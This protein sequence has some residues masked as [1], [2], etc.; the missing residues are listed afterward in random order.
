MAVSPPEGLEQLAN[1]VDD[2][3]SD[4]TDAWAHHRYVSGRAHFAA[5]MGNAESTMFPPGYMW[6]D[7]AAINADIVRCVKSNQMLNAAL[8]ALRDGSSVSFEDA[9]IAVLHVA[10]KMSNMAVDTFMGTCMQLV[11]EKSVEQL[12]SELFQMDPDE[13]HMLGEYRDDLFTATADLNQAKALFRTSLEEYKSAVD[14]TVVSP[15]Q[16]HAKETNRAKAISTYTNDIK[17]INSEVEKMT[18]NHDALTEISER[19]EGLKTTYPSGADLYISEDY[20]DLN[21]AKANI[22][23]AL[24][25][26]ELVIVS[27]LDKSKSNASQSRLSEKSTYNVKMNLVSHTETTKGFKMILS[28]EDYITKKAPQYWA[29]VPEIRRMLRDIDPNTGLHWRPSAQDREN[30]SMWTPQMTKVRRDQ[31]LSFA[32]ILLSEMPNQATA[33]AAL[34]ATGSYGVHRESFKA[35][36]ED[37]VEILW[38]YLQKI[39]PTD[40]AQQRIILDK[41]E[42]V[43]K[44]LSEGNPKA[45]LDQ[46]SELSQEASDMGAP[47]DWFRHGCIITSAL[48]SR[49]GPAAMRFESGLREFDQHPKNNQDCGEIIDDM[50]AIAKS[51]TDE[52]LNSEGSKAFSA[53]QA[54]THHEL[55]GAIAKAVRDGGKTAKAANTGRTP[56]KSNPKKVEGCEKG[57]SCQRVGCN[58]K[59]QGWTKVNNWK[60]CSTCILEVRTKGNAVPLKDGS[61][62]A[63][64]KEGDKQ[65]AAMATAKVGGAKIQ[66]AYKVMRTQKTERNRKLNAKRA[67]QEVS[68]QSEGEDDDPKPSKKSQKSDKKSGARSAAHVR[69]LIKRAGI[70]ND[71][72]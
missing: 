66:T 50:I 67:R 21:I 40:N 24:A 7:E 30:D 56:S 13:D 39:H 28:L 46:L 16:V 12:D 55:Q 33:R 61:T 57:G 44:K 53:M 43:A 31:A 52:L 47:L 54:M 64:R 69:N 3:Y 59:I 32:T 10:Q 2:H 17:F 41:I 45:Q 36:E 29:I 38:V 42:K 60:L 14:K 5:V 49:G 35:K 51:I 62:F 20:K 63:P 22:D 9:R 6:D 37:G 58:Q 65:L 1:T 19:I 70:G 25:L 48:T 18:Y 34:L 23:K 26:S 15:S 72:D 8:R 27:H 71:S 4:L 11:D 68:D